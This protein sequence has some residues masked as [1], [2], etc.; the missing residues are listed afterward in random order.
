MP[1]YPAAPMSARQAP[2]DQPDEPHLSPP[3][4]ATTRALDGGLARAQL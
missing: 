3:D 2:D 1:T 4:A